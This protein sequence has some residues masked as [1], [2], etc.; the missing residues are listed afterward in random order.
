MHIPLSTPPHDSPNLQEQQ[1][2]SARLS[3]K[4]SPEGNDFPGIFD[5]NLDLMAAKINNIF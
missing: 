5:K 4:L 2:G 3:E 1:N